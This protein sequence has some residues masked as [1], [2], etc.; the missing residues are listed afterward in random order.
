MVSCY[1]ELYT[2]KLCTFHIVSQAF[3]LSNFDRSTVGENVSDPKVKSMQEGNEGA[4][5]SS[6][7]S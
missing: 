5:H 7:L 3:L 2:L 6:L 1:G 4:P